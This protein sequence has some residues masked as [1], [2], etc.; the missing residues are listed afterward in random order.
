MFSYFK[1]NGKDGLHLAYIKDGYDWKSLK[2][3]TSF[4]TPEVGKDK[5]VRD[6]CIIKGGDGLF[7]MI[8]TVSC[9]DKVIGYASSKDLINW[10]QQQFLSVMSHENGTR[11]T[12]APE[13]TYDD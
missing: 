9:T 5:L 11:N 6:P 10:S 13:I 8:W 7:H 12:W 1:G 3:D 4:L 2:K